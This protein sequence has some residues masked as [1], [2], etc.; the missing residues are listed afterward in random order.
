MLP[1]WTYGEYFQNMIKVRS[2]KRKTLLTKNEKYLIKSLSL[3]LVVLVGEKDSH[4][5]VQTHKPARAHS[6][7][8]TDNALLFA[9]HLHRPAFG[10]CLSWQ[11]STRSQ[12]SEHD[13]HADLQQPKPRVQFPLGQERGTV[14]GVQVL[15]RGH[16][17]SGRRISRQPVGHCRRAVSQHE[18]RLAR[19]SALFHTHAQST[20]VGLEHVQGHVHHKSLG[21]HA[22]GRVRVHWQ[23]D[24]RVLE[25][26]GNAGALFGTV[27]LEKALG[28]DRV[29]EE[30]LCH[31]GLGPGQ[32]ARDYREVGQDRVRRE[33]LGGDNVELHAM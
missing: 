25:V 31:R 13:I 7:L 6:Q 16:H 20:P 26:Q 22:S 10:V 30:R 5:I 8:H 11:V 2:E 32:A 3:S 17:R 24:G 4:F 9:A 28:R 18:P 23:A 21:R 33:L 29:V 19:A 15:R 12:V 27:L 14:V 1:S